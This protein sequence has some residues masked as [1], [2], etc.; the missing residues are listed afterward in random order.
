[1]KNFKLTGKDKNLSDNFGEAILQCL[2]DLEMVEK[3]PKYEINMDTWH[4]PVYK[5]MNTCKENLAYCTVCFGGARL[6]RWVDDPTLLTEP[7]EQAAQ[8]FK[9]A[10]MDDVR[11]ASLKDAYNNFYETG[12]LSYEYFY[13][14]YPELR[15]I[16]DKHYVYYSDNPQKFKKYV[17]KVAEVLKEK[18]I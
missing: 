12:Y 4:Q 14:A 18:R 11:T 2:E 13:D 15:K 6:A 5:S 1:M 3:N 7:E 8:Y 9:I 17:K 10:A 16:I